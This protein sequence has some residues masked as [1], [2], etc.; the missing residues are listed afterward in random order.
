MALAYC[1]SKVGCSSRQVPALVI[2]VAT[3]AHT[4]AASGAR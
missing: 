2:A 1:S 3:V 4:S